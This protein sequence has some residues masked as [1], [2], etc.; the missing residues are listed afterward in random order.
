MSLQIAQRIE[1]DAPV[2][3]PGELIRVLNYRTRPAGWEQGEMFSST[4]ELENLEKGRWTY[5]V[6]IS[7]P[8]VVRNGRRLGGGYFVFVGGESIRK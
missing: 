2:A 8:V 4:Y 1:I 7:R 6:W 3:V 5:A